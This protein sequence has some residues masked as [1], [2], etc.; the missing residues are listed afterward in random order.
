MTAW[1]G[2]WGV[3]GGGGGGD[4]SFCKHINTLS[5]TYCMV[6]DA[7]FKGFIKY[8]FHNDVQVIII[9]MCLQ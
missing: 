3:G 1:G 5:N 7:V 9:F 4:N 2:G 8:I 6:Q